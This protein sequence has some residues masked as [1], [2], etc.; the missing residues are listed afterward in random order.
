M[1]QVVP[2]TP[3]PKKNKTYFLKM[4]RDCH[5]FKRLLRVTGGTGFWPSSRPRR[6]L[7]WPCPQSGECG[8]D[9]RCLGLEVFLVGG[10]FEKPWASKNTWSS[11]K[12]KIFW[13]S[14]IPG[15]KRRMDVW[16][17]IVVLWSF[18]GSKIPKTGRSFRLDEMARSA[19]Q[20]EAAKLTGVQPARLVGRKVVEPEGFADVIERSMVWCCEDV[21]FR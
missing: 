3:P 18:S 20:E 5:L 15:E 10:I 14:K 12:I 11:K 8:L 21:F 9:V 13:C 1:G 17:G 16:G 6:G 19:L 2:K 7:R 4:A